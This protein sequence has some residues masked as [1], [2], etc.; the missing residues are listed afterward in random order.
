VNN[1]DEEYVKKEI[2]KRNAA[3]TSLIVKA[4]WDVTSAT[5]NAIYRAKDALLH[6]FNEESLRNEDFC[7]EFA[8]VTLDTVED[9]KMQKLL[10]DVCLKEPI[11]FKKFNR[12]LFDNAYTIEQSITMYGCKI[13]DKGPL[14]KFMKIYTQPLE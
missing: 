4:P 10:R 8:K 6:Y 1:Y 3:L 7:T 9:Y 11:D 13:Y 2:V 14:R 5:C 12:E